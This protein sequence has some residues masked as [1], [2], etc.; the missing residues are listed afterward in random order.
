MTVF[1]A[2]FKWT[3]HYVYIY[4][5]L[6]YLFFLEKAIALHDLDRRRYN[7]PLPIVTLP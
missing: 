5:L 3:L 1:F 2:I 4:L 6:L 7:V